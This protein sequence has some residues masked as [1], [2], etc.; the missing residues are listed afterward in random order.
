MI[1]FRSWPFLVSCCL[2]I[3]ITIT[4]VIP[5][6]L[7]QGMTFLPESL[8]CNFDPFYAAVLHSY[9]MI[10]Q[11]FYEKNKKNKIGQTLTQNLWFCDFSKRI[12]MDLCCA[13]FLCVADLPKI[14]NKIDFETIQ[15]AVSENGGGLVFL[16]CYSLQKTF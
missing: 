12:N 3:T 4:S 14:N 1:V 15:R 7:F 9:Y 11:L 10:N 5:V 8:L 13:G 16:S 2:A 6:E